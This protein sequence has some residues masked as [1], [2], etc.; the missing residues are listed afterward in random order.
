MFVDGIETCKLENGTRGILLSVLIHVARP[1][2]QSRHAI[3]PLTPQG[4]QHIFAG[5]VQTKGFFGLFLQTV[6]FRQ[7]KSIAP[8]IWQ[9]ARQRC[10]HISRSRLRGRSLPKAQE[11]FPLPTV[12]RR[13]GR[14]IH[15]PTH[16]KSTANSARAAHP[17]RTE[18][19]K[20]QH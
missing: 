16:R 9:L 20:M 13:H 4:Y 18:S 17:E 3:A 1:P 11:S 7:T 15:T 14:H 19:Q 12:R 6:S 5:G 10:N 2:D 8:H